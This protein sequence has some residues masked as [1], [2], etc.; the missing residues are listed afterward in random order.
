MQA[1]CK[2]GAVHLCPPALAHWQREALAPAGDR[3][4][5]PSIAACLAARS[6]CRA[7]FIRQAEVGSLFFPGPVTRSSFSSCVPI[8][9]MAATRLASACC[10]AS[11]LPCVLVFQ[12]PPS[13]H[14][15]SAPPRTR[16]QPRVQHDAASQVPDSHLHP[17]WLG[18]QPLPARSR[19]PRASAGQPAKSS[20]SYISDLVPCHKLWAPHLRGT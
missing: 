1:W 19:G 11:A 13:Q 12:N 4:H 20:Q 6:R 16:A 3:L 14:R 8:D 17:P 9:D 2:P 10:T 15:Q 7:N 18:P 5:L